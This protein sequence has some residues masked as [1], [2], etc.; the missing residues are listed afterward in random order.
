VV[1]FDTHAPPEFQGFFRESLKPSFMHQ[2]PWE[3]FFPRGLVHKGG[4]QGFPEKSLKFRGGM[5][6]KIYH[7]TRSP[8][9]DIVQS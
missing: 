5:S 2:T 7:L 8:I 1:N 9:Y 4:F 3:K 6:I